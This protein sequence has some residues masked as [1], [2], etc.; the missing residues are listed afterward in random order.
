MAQIERK[1]LLFYYPYHSMDPFLRLLKEAAKDP[2]VI[3]IKITLYRV[4]KHSK[5]VN[6][7]IQAAEN[8]KEVGVMVELRP[9]SMKKTTST[10]Q[11]AGR[12]G[13]QRDLRPA[14]L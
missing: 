2:D 4:A 11:A 5:I 6:A 8:G 10:V 14:R 9:G 1:D 3:S 12:S 13:L 7:L